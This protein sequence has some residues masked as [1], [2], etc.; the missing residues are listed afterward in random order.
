VKPWAKVTDTMP[1][2]G[3]EYQRQ[4]VKA[5]WIRQLQ[6][7]EPEAEIFDVINSATLPSTRAR[8]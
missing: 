8:A 2:S 7:L 4:C 3:E 5:D 6:E 1:D